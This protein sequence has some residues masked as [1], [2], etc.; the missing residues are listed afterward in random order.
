ML[1]GLGEH[2]G[3]PFFAD[4]R[5]VLT[6][7]AVGSRSSICGRSAR[8]SSSSIC[9][10][11][12]RFGD[13]ARRAPVGAAP[14]QVYGL[15]QLDEHRTFLSRLAGYCAAQGL[16]AK[17]AVS[18]YAPGQLEVNLGHVDLPLRAADHAFLLKRAIKAAARAEGLLATFMAKPVAKQSRAGCTCT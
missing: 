4:P 15:D 6:A 12:C 16:P 14:G 13:A 2:G 17:S 1:A 8:S 18:E 7:V 5:A 11:R 9:S 10:R 3:G